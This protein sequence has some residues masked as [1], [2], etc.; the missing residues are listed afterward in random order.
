MLAR[1]RAVPAAAITLVLLTAAPLPA[2]VVQGQQPSA[3]DSLTV[4]DLLDISSASVGDLSSDGRW[5]ALTVT[6]RRDGLGVDFSRD[7]DPTYLLGTP[8]QLLVVDTR[9]L[10]QRP[11]FRTKM[12]V[13][14]VTWS[15][16]RQRARGRVAGGGPRLGTRVARSPTSRAGPGPRSKRCAGGR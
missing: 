8:A 13:R 10:A 4:R 3:S 11:V 16:S 2:R 1:L 5:L 9:T 15:P 14:G 6:V 7:G 12:I